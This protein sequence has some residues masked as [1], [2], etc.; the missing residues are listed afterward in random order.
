MVVTTKLWP[1]SVFLVTFLSLVLLSV[2]QGRGKRTHLKGRNLLLVVDL[3]LGRHEAKAMTEQQWLTCNDPTPMLE[4]LRGKA[5]DRKLRL[6]A[7]ACCRSVWHLLLDNSSRRAVEVAERFADGATTDEELNEARE[8]AWEFTD[9]GVV[10]L[11]EQ[12]PKLDSDALNAGDAPAWAA[13]MPDRVLSEKHFPPLRASI[14]AQRA[15]GS[16]EGKAQTHMLRDVFGNLFRPVAFNPAWL[17]P[18]VVALAQQVYDDRA[19]DRLP[20]L[21]DVLEQAGCHNAEILGHCRGPGP[22]VRGCWVVDL[23]LGKG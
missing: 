17:T 4:F 9:Y 13:E 6:F 19:F 14:A 8:N 1:L 2:A 7:C 12:F 23:L 3:V 15:L 10:N 5:S 22:H 20:N 18:K 11:I 21:V 16:S